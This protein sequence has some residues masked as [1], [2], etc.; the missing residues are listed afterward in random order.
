VSDLTERVARAMWEASFQGGVYDLLADQQ[1]AD[2]RTEARAAIREV[3][4]VLREPSAAMQSAAMNRI[5]WLAIRD[6]VDVFARE[7]GLEAPQEAQEGRSGGRY[8]CVAD[9]VASEPETLSETPRN[10][11][12]GGFYLDAN[13]ALNNSPDASLPP[14]RTPG[15]PHA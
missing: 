12:S 11:P 1:K 7:N 15:D 14:Y 5:G 4:A 6:A 9:A 2:I 3:L 10:R 8:G 13:S